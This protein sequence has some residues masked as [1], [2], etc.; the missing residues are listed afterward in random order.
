[1]F[2]LSAGL[3]YVTEI[4][5]IV[6]FQPPGDS[7]V[8]TTIEIIDDLLALENEEM[9]VLD[10]TVLEGQVTLGGNRK[11]TVK[12]QDNDGMFVMPK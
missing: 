9:L 11:S 2:F 7:V 3:D 5:N 1:M 10:L 4:L 8:C 12:I 6:N